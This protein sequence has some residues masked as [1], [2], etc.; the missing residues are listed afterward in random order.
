MKPSAATTADLLS[1]A[2]YSLAAS[3][4]QPQLLSVLNGLT[5]L[6]RRACQPYARILAAFHPG[7]GEAAIVTDVPFIPVGLFKS[8]ELV[9]VPRDAVFKT[10]TSSGTTGAQVSRIFLDRQTAARQTQALAKIMTDFLGQARLPMIIIDTSAV[11]SDRK[12]FSARGAGILGMMT[13]GRDHFFAVD[14]EM[15]LDREGLRAFLARHAD[16]PFLLFGFTF[17]V[18][19]YLLKALGDER[20]DLSRG[21]LVHGGGWKKLREQAVS[22]DRFKQ[23]L[24]DATGLARVHNFYGLVEQVGSIFVECQEGV[25]HT[26]C[27]AEVIVRDPRTLLPAP[28]GQ[29]GVIQLLSVLPES[30]PGHSLLTEDLG[31]LVG[32]DDCPCGRRGTTFHV[33]GR[34]AGVELRGC[35]DTHVASRQVA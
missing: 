11:L 7:A 6:H 19:Q 33:E 1:L 20:I 3:E 31:C 10:L 30:Y 9:S 21:V 12:S 13:F 17:M 23:G 28:R 34:V 2:P 29:T 32:V 14:A 16:G 35:S 8:H 15:N 24:H 25:L 5:E 26:P 4:K 22:N 27:F 18:W